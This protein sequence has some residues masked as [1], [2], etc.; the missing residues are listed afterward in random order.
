[1][2]T[3]PRTPFDGPVWRRCGHPRT[4]ENTVKDRG[5]R[6]CEHW[7]KVEYEA[8][9]AAER[10]EKRRTNPRYIGEIIAFGRR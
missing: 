7:R 5:C 10:R 2:V 9:R 4:P 6:F 8:R 1:M 3:I